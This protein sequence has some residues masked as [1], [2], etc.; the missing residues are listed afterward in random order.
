MSRRLFV[1]WFSDEHALVA[2]TAAARGQGLAIQDVYT[3]FAVHGIDE[4]MG[5][6]R[7]RLPWICLGAG[8]FGLL[9]GSFLQYYASVVS[10][11]LNVGG[12]P[13]N[14]AP[15]FLP[16]AFEMTVLFAALVSV[17]ALLVRTRLYPRLGPPA[18]LLARVTDDRF[19][20]VLEMADE[21]WSEAR[22]RSICARHGAVD[23]TVEESAS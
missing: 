8:V 13:F 18:G 21:G 7:S 22:A 16:V 17:L 9:F 11:P 3:P 5:L 4:A 19:A 20:L 15:A 1:G 23:V 2:A 12:K 10:W 14:S 6:R